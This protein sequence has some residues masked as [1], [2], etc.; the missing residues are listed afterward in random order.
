M[1]LEECLHLKPFDRFGDSRWSAMSRRPMLGLSVPKDPAEAR[2]AIRGAVPRLPGVYGMIDADERLI[3]VGKSKQ[4]RNRLIGYFQSRSGAEKSDRIA[5]L[6]ARIVWQCMPDELAALLRELELI[7]R[8]RPR[9]NV[10]GQPG[11]MP[12]TFV[13]IGRGPAPRA[14]LAAQPNGSER[15]RFGPL[16]GGRST[17]RAVQRLNDLAGLRDCPVAIPILFAGERQLFETAPSPRCIRFDL[18]NC[19]GPCAARCTESRYE[20]AV[21]AATAFLAGRSDALPEAIERQ[22]RSAAALHQFE[23]AAALRDGCRELRWLS[24][25]LERLREVRGRERFVYRYA[26]QPGRETWYFVAD[27]QVIEAASAPHNRNT[28]ACRLRMLAS[29][30]PDQRPFLAPAETALDVSILLASWF[31]N[32]RRELQQA[33]LPEEAIEICRT[34]I[35]RPAAV[36]DGRRARPSRSLAASAERT[37]S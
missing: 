23:R 7:H 17:Q 35:D 10:Q 8:W 2:A 13:C 28:A 36:A 14:Y 18:G 31:R 32:R 20:A 1:F 25:H 15:A 33:L 30:Y 16:R 11:R 29:E 5:G 19:L 26:D 24:E 3:Y 9:L 4:L 21:D 12:G 37:H 27:G 22:M 6:A 34:M